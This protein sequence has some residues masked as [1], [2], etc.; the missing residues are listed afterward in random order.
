M[1]VY[2][3]TCQKTMRIVPASRRLW[4]AYTLFDPEYLNLG[5]NDVNRWT[6]D[7]REMLSYMSDEDYVL[8]GLDDYLINSC[9]ATVFEIV[10]PFVLDNR[11]ARYELGG[12]F[13]RKK[14]TE[15]I[16]YI[17]PQLSIVEMSQGDPYRYSCQISLWRRDY[18]MTA[19][20]TP[21][22][23]WGFEVEG[24]REAA[25]DGEQVI[26]TVGSFALEYGYQ[27]ALSRKWQGLNFAGLS[28]EN[29]AIVQQTLSEG[30]RE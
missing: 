29:K 13:H 11:V 5:A 17:S 6:T 19:L 3:T 20:N 28:A 26:G 21:R 30:V 23:P 7:V 4:R 14:N 25:G 10:M 12:T 1:R 27:S 22:S 8:F 2:L 18:L 16:K 24:S 9:N 15:A